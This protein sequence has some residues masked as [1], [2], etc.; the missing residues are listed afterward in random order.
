M[1]RKTPRAITLRE[2]YAGAVQVGGASGDNIVIR[3]E[4][5]IS[6]GL[7]AY[8]ARRLRDWLTKW[9]DATS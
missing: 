2:K 4:P 7:S 3:F 8:Q 9:L 5:G 6:R 1:K